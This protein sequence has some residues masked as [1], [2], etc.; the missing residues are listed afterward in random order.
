LTYIGAA[1]EVADKT[2]E[3]TRIETRIVCIGV[4]ESMTA[5]RFVRRS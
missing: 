3:V 4:V 2:N 5:R 1:N